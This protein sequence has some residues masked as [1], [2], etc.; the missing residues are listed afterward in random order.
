MKEMILPPLSVR[1]LFLTTMAMFSVPSAPNSS[2]ACGVAIMIYGQISLT[3]MNIELF[4]RS[5]NTFRD[6]V[7]RL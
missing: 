6:K 3:A 1:V 5:P 4:P 2:T 7:V